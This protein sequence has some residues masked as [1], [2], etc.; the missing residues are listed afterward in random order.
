MKI[1]V[2]EA[3]VVVRVELESTRRWVATTKSGSFAGDAACAGR[4]AHEAEGQERKRSLTT[5]R[6][7]GG[8]PS[9]KFQYNH[10]GDHISTGHPLFPVCYCL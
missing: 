1:N 7:L 10:P 8:A 9:Y 4:C 2:E 6:G 5:R 3:E